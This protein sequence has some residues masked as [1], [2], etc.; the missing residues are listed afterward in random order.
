[1]SRK[2]LRP[3]LTFS[4]TVGCTPVFSGV[5]S[6]PLFTSPRYWFLPTL[7]TGSGSLGPQ[8]ES[9][10]DIYTGLTTSGS[11]TGNDDGRVR[12]RVSGLREGVHLCREVEEKGL[13][14]E[15]LNTWKPGLDPTRPEPGRPQLKPSPQPKRL[16]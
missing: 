12:L 1:M 9:E 4:L 7:E 13:G 3:G 5:L 14:E 15:P 2:S 11:F 10:V 16:V 8:E 6:N